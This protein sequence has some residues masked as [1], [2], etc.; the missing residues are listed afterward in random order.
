MKAPDL[1]KGLGPNGFYGTILRPGDPT[2][3]LTQ[4]ITGQLLRL[5]NNPYQIPSFLYD[6]RLLQL[7]KNKGMDLAELKDNRRI[8]VMSNVVKILEKAKIVKVAVLAPHMLQTR[9][10][11]TGFKQST[12]TATHMSRLLSQIHPG[13]GTKRRNYAALIDL[14]KAYD[15]INNEKICRIW[16]SRCNNESD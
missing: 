16:L 15:T 11:Q 7:S 12:S 9:I 4:N 14:Q 8:V 5:L 6:C 13:K 3:R 1:N 10:W 2:H